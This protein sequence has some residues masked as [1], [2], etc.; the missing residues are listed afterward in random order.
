MLNE[1]PVAVSRMVT[2][3]Q[4]PKQSAYLQG[5]GVVQLKEGKNTL[6]IKYH[7]TPCSTQLNQAANP[8]STA[9][10]QLLELPNSDELKVEQKTL[11][12][13]LALSGKEW[14]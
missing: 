2:S 5:I 4:D 12:Q 7:I 9:S 13:D 11:S 8:H 14:T 10:F 1:E 3:Q 6:D